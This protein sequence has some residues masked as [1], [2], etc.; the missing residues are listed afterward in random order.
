MNSYFTTYCFCHA[1]SIKFETGL[2]NLEM[3]PAEEV[4]LMK[5]GLCH[6]HF[7]K[8]AGL[9]KNSIAWTGRDGEKCQIGHFLFCLIVNSCYYLNIFLFLNLF[10]YSICSNSIIVLIPASKHLF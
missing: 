5:P 2:I 10:H 7:G 4:G 8:S 6:Q 9:Y 3:D 1:S